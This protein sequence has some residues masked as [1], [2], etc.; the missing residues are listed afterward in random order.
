MEIAQLWQSIGSSS[1][2]L[3]SS[4]KALEVPVGNCTALTKHWKLELETAELWQS[5]GSSSWQLHSSNKA[6]EVGVG[7]CPLILWSN[8]TWY[9][10]LQP[11]WSGQTCCWKPPSRSCPYMNGEIRCWNLPGCEKKTRWTL[12]CSTFG[13]WDERFTGSW[14]LSCEIRIQELQIMKG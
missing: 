12:S 8:E 10:K 2:K 4:N 9:W 5:I 1:W 6:L 11:L 13:R 7:N 3:H 14:K